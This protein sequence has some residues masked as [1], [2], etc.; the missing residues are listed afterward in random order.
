M[1][2]KGFKET[3]VPAHDVQGRK[4]ALVY[5]DWNSDITERLAISCRDTLLRNGVAEHNITQT[6]VPGA[7]ELIYASQRLM[8]SGSFDAVIAIGCVVRGGTPHFDYICQGVTQGIAMLNT[9]G[10]T[11][12]VFGIL[13]VNSYEQ[14]LA[15]CGGEEGDKGHEFALTAIKM[16]A[17]SCP[18][19]K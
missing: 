17:F 13:T 5:T 11:P 18:M 2:S 19:A 15:R 12:V 8:N 16:A 14:A 9:T 7:F 6:T 1:S 10:N 4:F 3:S